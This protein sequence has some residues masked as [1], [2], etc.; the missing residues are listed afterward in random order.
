MTAGCSARG[1]IGEGSTRRRGDRR[2]ARR[3]IPRD[4]GLGTE[5][6]ASGDPRCPGQVRDAGRVGS[7][8][9]VRGARVLGLRRFDVGTLCGFKHF[10][11]PT[12]QS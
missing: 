8:D 5:G 2:E 9:D 11:R 3:L 4:L 10:F 12:S 7:V 6:L 1:K